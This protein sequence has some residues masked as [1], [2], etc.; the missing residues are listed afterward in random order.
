MLERSK[1]IV[2]D[3]NDDQQARYQALVDDLKRESACWI[4]PENIKEKICPEL[5]DA[6]C[7]TGFVSKKSNLWRYHAIT[8]KPERLM[9]DSFNEPDSFDQLGLDTE[10]GK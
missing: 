1:A 5:F 6:P 10:D 4:T 8:F 2:S 3:R 7:T 9:L